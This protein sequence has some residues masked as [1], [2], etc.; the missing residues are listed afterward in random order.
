MPLDLVAHREKEFKSD[1]FYS[2]PTQYNSTYIPLVQQ[3][4]EVRL[5]LNT[6]YKVYNS[7][8]KN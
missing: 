2:N 1:L 7:K 4:S 6:Y 5:V 8:T 3:L